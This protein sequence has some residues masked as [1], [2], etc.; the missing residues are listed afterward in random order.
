MAATTDMDA[1]WGPVKATALP[2][3]MDFVRA[4]G[5]SPA[6]FYIAFRGEAS[7]ASGA[8]STF[9]ADWR[10]TLTGTAPGS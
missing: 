7:T 6:A 9:A 5:L 1:I 3:F 2:R 4:H 8:A 10:P